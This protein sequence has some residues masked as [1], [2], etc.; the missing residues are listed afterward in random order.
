M[1]GG[2]GGENFSR[3]KEWE[4]EPVCLLSGLP[5]CTTENRVDSKAWP[6]WTSVPVRSVVLVGKAQR[7][8]WMVLEELLP[9]PAHGG[10][11][12]RGQGK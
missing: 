3:G 1:V 11:S 7:K 10:R 4:R 8:T 12:G 9:L 6:L 5:G 2:D